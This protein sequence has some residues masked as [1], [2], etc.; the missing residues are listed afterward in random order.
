[1]LL[2]L[3]QFLTQFSAQLG[4]PMCVNY[5]VESFL[6][7]T[8]ATAIAMNAWRLPLGLALP[9][10]ETPWVESVGVGWTFGIAGF[11]CFGALLMILAVASGLGRTF[12]QHK[13]SQYYGTSEDG[14]KIIGSSRRDEGLEF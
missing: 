2:A 8:I 12:R 9:F 14:A 6:N 5:A 11:L 10:I 7:H 3:S 1:M 4:V 13:I